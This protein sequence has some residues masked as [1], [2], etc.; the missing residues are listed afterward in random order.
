MKITTW[1]R[2]DPRDP[3]GRSIIMRTDPKEEMFK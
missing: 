3:T 1:I 2:P